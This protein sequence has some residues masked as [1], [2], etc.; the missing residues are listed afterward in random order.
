MVRRV[1][2]PFAAF[3][4]QGAGCGVFSGGRPAEQLPLERATLRVGVGSAIDTAPLRLAV[5][6]GRFQ[7][8]GLRVEL[9]ELGQAD[10]LKQLT[11][12]QLDVAFT[13]DVPMFRAAAA[14]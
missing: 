4:L 10:G 12:G 9:V 6:D 5:S 13:N 14:G 11:T 8:A 1:G 3:F 2:V 7:S